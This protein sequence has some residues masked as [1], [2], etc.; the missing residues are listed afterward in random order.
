M[1]LSTRQQRSLRRIEDSL[2]QSDPGFATTMCTFA[3][4]EVD[5]VTPE[6]ERLISRARWRRIVSWVFHAGAV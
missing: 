1:G 4:F 5:G 6:Q 3:V 2:R